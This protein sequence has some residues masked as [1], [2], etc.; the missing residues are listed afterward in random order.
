M[1]SE[2]LHKRGLA[3]R[4]GEGEKMLSELSED[5]MK[6]IREAW[7]RV[8]ETIKQFIETIKSVAVKLQDILPNIVRAE[9]PQ[10][11]PRRLFRE[12]E[13]I[14]L[15]VIRA[16]VRQYELNRLYIIAMQYKPP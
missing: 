6:R 14:K 5:D 12:R 11:P 3:G 10:G 16:K 15:A 4:N 1:E 7:K 13:R 2:L 8:Q 9:L